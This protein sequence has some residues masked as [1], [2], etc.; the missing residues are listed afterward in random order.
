MQP[1]T[2]EP[3]WE[4][5]V[6]GGNHWSG[7]LRRGSA[8]RLTDCEGGA[9]A[10]MLLFNREEKLERYNMPD[11]LKGQHTA[12]LT[13]GNV[14]YSDMG[15]VLASI[16]RDEI[17]WHDTLCGV[18]DDAGILALY[19]EKTFATA[20]NE[21]H[22]SG[23]EGLLIEL[24]KHGLGKRDLGAT[25]NFFSKV[26]ADENGKLAYVENHSRAGNCVDLRFEMD[27]LIA[28]SAAP[29][30]LDSRREYSP[31]AVKLSAFCA[32]A[33]REDDLCR[34]HCEQNA[35]AFENTARL[36]AGENCREAK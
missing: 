18:S 16:I 10:S 4:E 2:S 22:R 28:L 20:R 36:F 3:L 27:V 11:T 21:M 19:G 13:A 17:G 1:K 32:P 34:T 35:R 6:P 5:I 9:N 31:T 8:L 30:P 24:G 33:P 12:F 29:H 15:R 25:V 26:A 14:L 23:R 7:V